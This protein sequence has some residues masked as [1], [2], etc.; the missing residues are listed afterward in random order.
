MALFF[1]QYLANELTWKEIC[2]FA[3]G[4]YIFYFRLLRD[5]FKP[6]IQNEAQ[7]LFVCRLLGPFLFRFYSEKPR[8][9][10][11]VGERKRLQ[12]FSRLASMILA[13][14]WQQ[15]NSSWETVYAKYGWLRMN[16]SIE[17]SLGVGEEKTSLRPW[18][19]I[20]SRSEF[21]SQRKN[22]MESF[23]CNYS[24]FA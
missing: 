17:F 11:E 19:E 2:L 9:L 21:F 24:Y 12:M 6:L 10:L 1:R 5:T 16:D 13:T 15:R 8:C 7:F 20:S 22:S 4:I 18:V 14:F 23:I 3:Y